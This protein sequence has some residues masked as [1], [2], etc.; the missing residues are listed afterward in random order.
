[1]LNQLEQAMDDLRLLQS[2]FFE[3]RGVVEGVFGLEGGEAGGEVGEFLGVVGGLFGL[4]VDAFAE[5][6][7]ANGDDGYETFGYST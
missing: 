3:T 4:G 5:V 1:M 7:K 2:R 6:V